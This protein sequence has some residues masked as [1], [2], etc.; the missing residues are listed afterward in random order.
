MTSNL[1]AI[2]EPQVVTTA[3]F[4]EHAKLDND[5]SQDSSLNT[6]LSAATDQCAQYTRRTLL[7]STWRATSRNFND[8]EFDIA[9]VDASTITIKYYDVDN[10]LQD[11]PTGNYEISDNGPDDYLSVKFIAPMPNLYDRKDAVVIEY[12]AGYGIQNLPYGIKLGI[13]MNATTHLEGRQDEVVG[14]VNTVSMGSH[15]V[16]FPYKML[17]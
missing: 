10:A 17:G 14:T 8:G 5:G 12:S 9:P 7:K 2:T 3:D 16:M 4:R 11:L 6:F 1:V 15:Q 13:L